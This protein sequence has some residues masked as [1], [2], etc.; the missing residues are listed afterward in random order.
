MK[1]KDGSL[2]FFIDYLRLNEVSHKDA[3]PLPRI[4]SCLDAMAGALWF[5]TFD[6]RAGYHQVK[7]DRASA[8]K[9]MFITREGTF[10]FKVMPFRLTG[11]P[12]T[13]QRLMDLVM[14]GLNP[15]YASSIWTTSSCFRLESTNILTG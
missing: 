2:R 5:S 10:N 12:A 13:F 15:R 8:E 6:L 3:Y 1:K 11:A 7:M 9:T 4:D 14:A